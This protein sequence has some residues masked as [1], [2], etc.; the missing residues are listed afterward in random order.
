MFPWVLLEHLKQ[1]VEQMNYDTADAIMEKLNA[2]NYPGKLKKMMDT[3]NVR[4]LNL[5]TEEA[6]ETIQEIEREFDGYGDTLI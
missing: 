6:L 2:C 5:Q 4:I 1:E 3:L